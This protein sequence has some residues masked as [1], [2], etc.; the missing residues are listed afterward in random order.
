MFWFIFLIGIL[1]LYSNVKVVPV[2]RCNI[3]K[4]IFIGKIFFNC[5]IEYLARI[6]YWPNRK[7]GIV[8]FLTNCRGITGHRV[9]RGRC[10]KLQVR[11]DALMA[12]RRKE[13]ETSMSFLVCD[14]LLSAWDISSLMTGRFA[15]P[16]GIST[17][18]TQERP[19]FYFPAA[20][21]SFSLHATSFKLLFCKGK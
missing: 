9:G 16:C 19:L 6:S 3:L 5:F 1:L 4:R 15:P 7:V 11:A 17:P 21:F 20:K 18:H 13:R 8:G 12:A 2:C 14:V 10:S